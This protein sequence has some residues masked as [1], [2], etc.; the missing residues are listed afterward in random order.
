MTTVGRAFLRYLPRRKALTCLQVL[1]IAVGVAAAVG[2]AL[3]ARAALASFERA[4]DFL[5]GRATHSLA[6]P[7]GPLDETLLRSIAADPAV[8]A[9]SPVV[10]RRLLLPGGEGVRLLGVDPFLDRR[11]RPDLAPAEG[12]TLDFLFE[13]RGALV[14]ADLAARLGLE[15]GS[16]L[17][18]SHGELRLL[19][20]FP[21][22]AGEPL[23]V[24]DLGHAQELVGLR[25]RVDR[26]DLILSDPEGFAARWSPGFSVRSVGQ[27]RAALGDLL[28]AFRLN[29]EALSLV[30]L[31]VGVFLVYNTAMFAVVSR[32]R[33]AGILFALGAERREVAAAF[34]AELLLLGGVGGALGGAL[35][36]GLSRTLTGLLGGAIS[37]LYAFLRPTPPEWS[38][39]IGAAGVLLGWASCLLGGLHPL[40]ELVRADPVAAL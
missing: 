13:P 8:D 4:V 37:N 23:A 36:W 28:R 7:A 6:R 25:G 3:S 40:R 19:G 27:S 21:N 11:F 16:T 20:T 10:D 14:G 33:D 39:G 18:T 31:F 12:G 9:F 2:M 24:L 32:R 35:G 30:G 38:W 5:R 26:V 1:G 15:V 29:L 22:P 17:A 34:L